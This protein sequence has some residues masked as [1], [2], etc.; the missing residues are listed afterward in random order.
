M[1]KLF[2]CYKSE[3]EYGPLMQMDWLYRSIKMAEK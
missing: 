2:L 1:V 3:S